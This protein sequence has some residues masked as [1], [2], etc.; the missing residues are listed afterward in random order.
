MDGRRVQRTSAPASEQPLRVTC[1]RFTGEI[2]IKIE[3]CPHLALKTDKANEQGSLA[4]GTSGLL[5]QLGAIVREANLHTSLHI[6][7]AIYFNFAYSL[8]QN[9]FQLFSER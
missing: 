9:F 3:N 6:C 4:N 8:T 2:E 5:R 7:W 1:L